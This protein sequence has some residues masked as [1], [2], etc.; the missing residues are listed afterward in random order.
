MENKDKVINNKYYDKFNSIKDK[1]K[2]EN[3][4]NFTKLGINTYIHNCKNSRIYEKKK[5]KNNLSK[6]NETKN[7][8]KQLKK[9][10]CSTNNNREDFK[11]LLNN[12]DD[13]KEK[14]DMNITEIKTDGIIKNIK[15]NKMKVDDFHKE[16]KNN[17]N[18]SYIKKDVYNT[19]PIERNKSFNFYGSQNNCKEKINNSQL[20][21]NLNNINNKKNQR[22]A[23]LISVRSF[24]KHKDLANGQLLYSEYFNIIN[25]LNKDVSNFSFYQYNILNNNLN[26]FNKNNNTNKANYTYSNLTTPGKNKL[27][28][29]TSQ[30]LLSFKIIKTFFAHL[31]ILVS[32]YLKRNFNYFK[33]KL[34]EYINQK[35]LKKFSNEKKRIKNGPIINVNNAH[36]SLFCSINI[37]QDNNNNNNKLFNTVFN[38]N[39]TPI[40]KKGEEEKE[41]IKLDKNL[42]NKIKKNKLSFLNN[43]YNISTNQN[44]KIK[45]EIN[46]SVYIPKIKI[47]K[48]NNIISNDNKK[49]S[50]D[51][52][53]NRE[54]KN[55]N[56]KKQSSPIKEMNINLKK[57]NVCKLNELNQLYLSQNLYNNNNNI[58]FTDINNILNINNNNNTLHTK[59]NSNIIQIDENDDKHNTNSNLSKG[60]FYKLKKLSSVKS[61]VYT[62]PKEKNTKKIIKE[63]K[64]QKNQSTP[65]KN[66]INYN[67]NNSNKSKK[68]STENIVTIS[69]SFLKNKNEDLLNNNNSN[70]SKEK[71]L[72]KKIYIRRKSKNENKLDYKESREKTNSKRKKCLSNL[73]SFKKQVKTKQ[74]FEQNEILIKHIKTS[75]EKLYINIKYIILN[76]NFKTNNKIYDYKTLK[77]ETKNKISIINNKFV[78]AESMINNIKFEISDIFSFDNDE[79]KIM[80]NKKNDNNIEFSNKLK[81]II[82][83]Y[84]RKKIIKLIFEFIRNMLLRKIIANNNKKIIKKYFSFLQLKNKVYKKNRNKIKSEKNICGIYHK[85][86]YND[87]FNINKRM[88]IPIDNEKNN[89]LDN[90]KTK[91]YT[92]TSQNSIQQFKNKNKLK[93]K[94][95]ELSS[96][97]NFNKT[98]KFINKEINIIVHNN[99]TKL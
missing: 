48:F 27:S 76:N 26:N 22:K 74:I 1:E 17:S 86:N 82:I 40:M 14:K 85:I 41:N 11:K 92:L 52:E 87:D 3:L 46:K 7:R 15:V 47:T 37:N 72:I 84:I 12:N 23:N 38:S 33:D 59:F 94:R 58:N 78:I 91:V 35:D 64:I 81:S 21:Y 6:I 31:E 18:T 49:K 99:N 90:N 68:I 65:F 36:C 19:K 93:N 29:S 57:I 43:E 60:K 53:D 77:K 62:K 42:I 63:I 51:I 44:N 70:N 95:R 32:L 61:D 97:I 75:D 79:K 56:N 98:L 80:K 71:N 66:D 34:K 10:L 69:N 4:Q 2:N 20:L 9:Y 67:K 8:Q 13:E 45:K 30:A 73:L 54:I 55:Y 89:N 88:K 28:S 83:K 96:S 24:D 50:A 25:P 39:N 16:N 5:D